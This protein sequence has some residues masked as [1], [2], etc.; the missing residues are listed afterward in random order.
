[1]S[2]CVLGKKTISLA[3]KNA[4][5]EGSDMPFSHQSQ[6]NFAVLRWLPAKPPGRSSGCTRLFFRL[7]LL[8]ATTWTGWRSTGVRARGKQENGD[9]INFWETYGFHRPRAANW[10]NQ[11]I[12]QGSGEPASISHHIPSE[13][14]SVIQNYRKKLGMVISFQA[15]LT[16]FLLFFYISINSSKHTTY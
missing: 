1:M 12:S 9:V 16:P 15:S 10:D 3:M 11:M 8:V 2:H 13:L 5:Y 4:S 6:R 7:Q 14:L